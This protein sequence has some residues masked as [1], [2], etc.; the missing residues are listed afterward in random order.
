MTRWAMV[1]DLE[2]CVGCQT[3]TAACRHANATSPAVQWRK[4]LDVE[5]G[6]YPQVSRT[7]VPVGCQHCADPPCMH[8][9]PST[10]TRQRAD[11]I[12]TIDY[13][14]CIGCAYCDVACPYQARFK[15]DAMGLAYGELALK[16][17]IER[18]D[19]RRVG[20]AQKCNFCSDRIDFGIAN[21]VVPGRDP[22]ATPA[23]VNACIADALHFG[24]L[25]DPDSNV[26]R[27]LREQQHFRMH[28]ELGT[29]PG[30]YYLYGAAAAPD[31]PTQAG[32]TAAEQASQL[33][34]R[35]VEPW[36]QR[37]W[38]WKAAGNF[39]CGG[40][41]SGL[42]V[43]ATVAALRVGS[44]FPLPWLALALIAL[45]LFLVLLK[46]GRPW[47]AAYVL[48]Q[49][50]R[51][52]MTREAWVAFALFPVGA[53]AAALEQPVLMIAAAMLALLFLFSQAM[54]LREAKGI[55]AWRTPLIVPLV[56]ATGMAEGAG[57]L[58]AGTALLPHL[59]PLQQEAA[60]AVIILAA[61]R[62]WCWSSYMTGLRIVGTPTRALEV[63]D[64]FRPWFFVFG[65]AAP[66]LLALLGLLATQVAAGLFP[67]AGVSVVGAGAAF[68]LVLVTRAGFNQGFALVHTPARGAGAP[69][70]AV[71]PGWSIR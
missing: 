57:L 8:V 24:D 62:S 54:I 26:S 63:L 7:F 61:L 58:L 43:M 64:A 25:D 50:Q 51:S 42:L 9:C 53:L 23:C 6:T 28:D 55:P 48:R 52:W 44:G 18:E 20:V 67:L 32:R 5:A 41:G 65:L 68:K 46:I 22:R 56:L 47:R 35:G 59:V 11:G 14:I 33:R 69:G 40:M 66:T 17:E 45:G 21:G 38:D 13:D 12:V 27:L 36:H 31:A 37:H 70:G 71:K 16:N 29:E 30:F 4:V 39:I 10:A 15:V 49:P 1:A 2:R 34:T 3:C 60:L 19:P